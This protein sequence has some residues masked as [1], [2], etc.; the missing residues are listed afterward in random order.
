MMMNDNN[1]LILLYNYLVL[2]MDLHVVMHW[3]KHYHMILDCDEQV[4]DG[5]DDNVIHYLLLMLDLM[6]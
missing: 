3:M 2:K 4:D 5:G 6:D 1:L